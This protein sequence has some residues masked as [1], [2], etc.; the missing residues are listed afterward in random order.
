MRL[1][2]TRPDRGQCAVRYSYPLQY[3]LTQSRFFTLCELIVALS[4]KTM[5]RAVDVSKQSCRT[6]PFSKRICKSK[7]TMSSVMR[8]SSKKQI[9]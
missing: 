9:M 6:A 7:V 1:A 8:S 4:K 5:E 2:N 3:Y